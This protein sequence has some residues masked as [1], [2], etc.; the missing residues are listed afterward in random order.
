MA[1]RTPRGRRTDGESKAEGTARVKAATPAERTGEKRMI[2]RM[3]GA[4]CQ[5]KLTAL[6]VDFAGVKCLGM[7]RMVLSHSLGLG[8]TPRKQWTPKAVNFAVREMFNTDASEAELKGKLGTALLDKLMAEDGDGGDECSSIG[9]FSRHTG[10][11][12][13]AWLTQG[14]AMPRDLCQGHV[15]M[16]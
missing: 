11:S 1:P 12:S 15:T 14:L 8:V 10:R 16:D 3:T 9:T 4:E 7:P 5:A 2:A 13:W 6:G